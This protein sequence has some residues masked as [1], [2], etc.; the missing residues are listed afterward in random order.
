MDI[1][2][3]NPQSRDQEP[4]LSSESFW[5]IQQVNSSCLILKSCFDSSSLSAQDFCLSFNHVRLWNTPVASNPLSGDVFQ[6]G[7]KE[8]EPLPLSCCRILVPLLHLDGSLHRIELWHPPANEENVPWDHPKSFYWFQ[9]VQG[10]VSRAEYCS[11]QGPSSGQKSSGL[12]EIMRLTGTHLLLVVQT[13]QKKSPL[14][15]PDDT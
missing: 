14:M 5:T 11:C 9:L 4:H 3:S 6:C 8:L 7:T 2:A 12:L 13:L 15:N 10:W 1:Q